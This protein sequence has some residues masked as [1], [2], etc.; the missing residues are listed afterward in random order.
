MK[1]TLK[2]LG[3]I[4]SLTACVGM[5]AGCGGNKQEQQAAD[6]GADKV[7]KIGINQFADHPSLDNCRLGF[8]DGLKEAGYVEGVNVEFLY[9]NGLADTG[10]TNQIAQNYVANKCDLICGIATPAAQASYNAAEGKVP[11]IYTAVSDPVAAGLAD[12]QGLGKATTGTS[13][14][15]PLEKQ[16]E[17]I[18]E[19][20]EQ[21]DKK[22]PMAYLE[23][24]I[25]ELTEAGSREFQN[26]W[27]FW[28]KHFSANFTGTA[29]QTNPNNPTLAVVAPTIDSYP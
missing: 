4:L 7:Y 10:I 22:Q 24:S 28:S 6:N 9:D 16:V 2:K 25:V 27:S 21:S 20:I 23:M 13:D 12:E 18:R 5:L 8:I 1:K 29:F 15:L 17:M 14:V 11:V 26:Q 19:F 3:M